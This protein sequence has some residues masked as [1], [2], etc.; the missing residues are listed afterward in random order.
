MAPGRKRAAPTDASPDRASGVSFPPAPRRRRLAGDDGN[1]AD[2]VAGPSDLQVQAAKGN[3]ALAQLSTR[4]TQAE[5]HEQH[6]VTFSLQEARDLRETLAST[7]SKFYETPATKGDILALLRAI[8]QLGP[9]HSAGVGF[10]QQHQH[11]FLE[12]EPEPE[13]P[14]PFQKLPFD[15]LRLILIQL[16]DL[17]L[18]DIATESV[19]D[20]T[21]IAAWFQFIRR[22][23]FCS[24]SLRE[25]CTSLMASEVVTTRLDVLKREAKRYAADPAA[26]ERVTRWTLLPMSYLLHG[27]DRDIGFVIPDL[28]LSMSNL[29]YLN[30]GTERSSGSLVESVIRG[31]RSLDF[32]SITGGV[33]VPDTIVASLPNLRELVY[34]VPTTF[35]SVIKFATAIPSLRELS[36]VDEVERLDEAVVFS[37]APSALRRLWLPTT[38]LTPTEL[39]KLLG[40]DVDAS[41][42]SGE[43]WPDSPRPTL[44][45]LAFCFDADQVFADPPLPTQ[46]TVQECL[47][48]ENLFTLIGRDLVALQLSTPGA[49]EPQTLSGLLWLQAA[50]IQGVRR[51]RV[52]GRMPGGGGGA[53]GGGVPPGVTFAFAFGG[54]NPPLPPAAAAAQP[55]APAQLPAAAAQPA[56]GQQQQQQPQQQNA[57]LPVL[58]AGLRHLFGLGGG[59]GGAGGGGGGANANAGQAQPNGNARQAQQNADP[60]RARQNANAGGAPPQNANAN[61]NGNANATGNAPAAPRPTARRTG[62]PPGGPPAPAPAP[63][64]AGM[65]VHCPR[66][67][68]LELFGRRYDAS[69]VE[70]LKDRPLRRLALSVPSDDV[71]EAV[72][73]KLLS[74]I[75]AG[76][77]PDLNRL[78]LSACG[79]NWPPAERRKFMQAASARPKLLYRS[80]DN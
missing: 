3:S 32:D 25:V 69:L 40:V 47:R 48:L 29:T 39:G 73:N 45:A 26:A 4:I 15:I 21:G 42:A 76:L 59:G 16:R 35:D 74:S 56:P 33:S 38:L 7:V 10:G 49:D 61:A 18:D 12:D 22:L 51:R 75:E 71:R 50:G 5:E 6:E 46:D 64:F 72:V 14:S 9:G 2:A 78:E 54:P 34:G 65:V 30:I 36:V 19:L 31:G 23:Q 66:L 17:Y 52:Q 77:W 57:V 20:R 67:E 24:S 62:P 1:P 41:A 27:S 44:D 63:F 13:K 68:R 79:G 70:L 58:G 55:A 80:T 60:R 11:L 43:D 53:R 37:Q 8:E 28:I